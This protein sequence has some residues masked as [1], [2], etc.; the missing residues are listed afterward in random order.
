MVGAFAFYGMIEFL[1]D[2]YRVKV[3][4]KGYVRYKQTDMMA[5]FNTISKNDV[6]FLTPLIVAT[7]PLSLPYIL[8]CKTQG[9]SVNTFDNRNREVR[10]FLLLFVA[11]A[12]GE[13]AR[14]AR[15]EVREKIYVVISVRCS[16]RTEYRAYIR[17][18][19][20]T[21]AGRGCWFGCRDVLPSRVEILHR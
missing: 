11:L 10:V 14:S 21:L 17:C 13:V 19:F 1:P 3:G 15:G 20:S 6:V 2:W 8:L 5:F 18:G 12:I 7:A 9:R 4:R 16:I